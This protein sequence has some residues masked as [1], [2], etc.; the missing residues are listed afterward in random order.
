MI[1]RC[2]VA[3]RLSTVTISGCRDNVCFAI[4]KPVAASYHD[5]IIID[6]LHCQIYIPANL[7]FQFAGVITKYLYRQYIWPYSM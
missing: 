7:C 4:A 3:L 1:V 2:G 5:D 6:H